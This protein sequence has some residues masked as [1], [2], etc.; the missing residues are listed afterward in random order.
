L[1][2]RTT[3]QTQASYTIEERQKKV[4]ERSDH[5]CVFW[6]AMV[7]SKIKNPPCNS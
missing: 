7:L 1:Q 5:F 3:A 6:G 4:S 2:L